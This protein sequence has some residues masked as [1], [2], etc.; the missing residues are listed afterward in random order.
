MEELLIGLILEGKVEGKI[1]QVAQRLEITRQWA[2]V[3]LD[4]AYLVLIFVYLANH[5]HVDAMQL[6]TNGPARS[7]ISTERSQVKALVMRA[8]HEVILSDWAQWERW[9]CRR[10]VWR[11]YATLVKS[12]VWLIKLSPS[13]FRSLATDYLP[14]QEG[15]QMSSSSIKLTACHRLGICIYWYVLQ[16][17]HCANS[18]C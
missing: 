10:R 6:L 1:D 2:F 14:I 15:L 8:M 17:L 13:L 18:G 9:W 11:L 3:S 7:K 5:C 16:L 4:M 12:F